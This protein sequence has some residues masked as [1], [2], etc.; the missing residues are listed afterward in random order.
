[1]HAAS[2]VDVAILPT[3]PAFPLHAELELQGEVERACGRPV[4]LIRLDLATSLLKWN[5][6]RSGIPV[7]VRSRSDLV[8]FVAATALEYADIAPALRRAEERFR[9]RL[10]AGTAE[11]ESER[12]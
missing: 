7:S 12:S 3:D 1:M 11:P 9:S 4:D 10:A 6:I 5:I 8:R 2:D